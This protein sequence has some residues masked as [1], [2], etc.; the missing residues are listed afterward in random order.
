MFHIPPS[1]I[2]DFNRGCAVSLFSENKQGT[3]P[4]PA[5]GTEMT[6][7]RAAATSAVLYRGSPILPPVGLRQRRPASQQ[8]VINQVQV[9]PRPIVRP[10]P[11]RP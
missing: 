8:E 5:Q 10:G 9:T 1:A 7:V 11:S 6:P 3:A 4:K 2:H